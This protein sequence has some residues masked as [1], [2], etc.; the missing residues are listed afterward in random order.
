VV[1]SRVLLGAR[2]VV[3]YQVSGRTTDGLVR[4]GQ[5]RSGLAAP[6][7]ESSSAPLATEAYDWK[8]LVDTIQL[9]ENPV[10]AI[11]K[12]GTVIAW[13][14]AIE[15]LTGVEGIADR[16]QDKQEYAIPF[17]GMPVP[18]LIDCLIRPP[19]S[20]VVAGQ[21]AT[22]K[23]GDTVIGEVEHVVIKGKPMLLEARAPRSMMRMVP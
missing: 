3:E 7:P 9:L 14:Q 10:F 20:P 8:G 4:I 6:A 18:M 17:Y 21:P 1:V 5:N 2:G 11:D 16:G 23:V 15:Q 12:R 22:R 13:N 19:D